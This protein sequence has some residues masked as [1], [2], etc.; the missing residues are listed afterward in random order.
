[1]LVSLRDIP[2]ALIVLLTLGF[3]RG[4][5]R[6]SVPA[7]IGCTVSPSAV[8]DFV[9]ARHPPTGTFGRVLRS[10]AS[11]LLLVAAALVSAPGLA[12]AELVG[13][14]EAAA[15]YWGRQHYDDCTMMA[16]ADVV[17]QIT[18][19]KPTEDELIAPAA[20][21][22]NGEGSGPIYS[23]RQTK[24]RGLR[25]ASCNCPIFAIFRFCWSVTASV[26]FTPMTLSPPT[27]G[28]PQESPL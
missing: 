27:V 20:A 22:P 15:Q 10:R 14:P 7:P 9:P 16:V 6:W 8:L 12:Y 28:C 25:P 13:D 18:G 2:L 5:G 4:A 3:C 1:M 26:R 23:R 19:A 21:T 17:G 24:R 11:A